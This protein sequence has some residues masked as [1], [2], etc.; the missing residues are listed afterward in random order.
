MIC[1]WMSGVGVAWLGLIC[2]IN[3][4]NYAVKRSIVFSQYKKKSNQQVNINKYPLNQVKSDLIFS[5]PVA[6][7]EN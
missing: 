5:W 4:N 2:G 7:R 1:G 6:C 3:W